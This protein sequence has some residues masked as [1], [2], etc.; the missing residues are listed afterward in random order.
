MAEL[1]S[2]AAL[3]MLLCP[4]DPA[5]G[6]IKAVKVE[7]DTTFMLVK[8]KCGRPCA[9]LHAWI[10]D[11]ETTKKSGPTGAIL[12]TS[13]RIERALDLSPSEVQDMALRLI[14][15][16]FLRMTADGSALKAA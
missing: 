5:E 8:E 4:G 10:N 1:N 13:S 6:A 2:F 7:K 3:A 16:G 14:R 12:F 11:F 15:G 9:V